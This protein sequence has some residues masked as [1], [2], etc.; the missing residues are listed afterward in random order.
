MYQFPQKRNGRNMHSLMAS[1]SSVF[2]LCFAKAGIIDRR[3]RK[4]VEGMIIEEEGED[5]RAP[6]GDRIKGSKVDNVDNH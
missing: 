3:D 5:K 2:F 1:R 4:E 6:G